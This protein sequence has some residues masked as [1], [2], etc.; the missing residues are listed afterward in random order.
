MPEPSKLF[1]SGGLRTSAA[2]S[3]LV[4]ESGQGARLTTQAGETYFDLTCGY[5]ASNFGQAFPPLVAAAT[6]QLGRLTHVTGEQHVGKIELARALIQ[7]AAAAYQLPEDAFRVQ[8]NVTGARAVETAWKAAVA[9]RPGRI[10]TLSPGFHGRSL[11]TS[12][13]SH[14]AR[15]GP[16]IQPE[17][18]L[19]QASGAYPYC[20]AC[21]LGLRY[22]ECK[23]ACAEPLWQRIASEADSISAVLVEPA[24]GARGYLFPPDEFFQR[25]RQLTQDHGILMIADEVQTGLGR[26]GTWLL[27][28]AQGWCPDL[29]VLGKSLGGGLAPISAVVG[30]AEVLDAIPAGV[31]SET[32]AGSPLACSLART[33]LETLHT[34]DWMSRG[35]EVG[36]SLR[37][38]CRE[39]VAD[40]RFAASFG[41]VISSSSPAVV[42]QVEGRGANC[43]VEF[44]ASSSKQRGSQQICAARVADRMLAAGLLVHLSGPYQTRIVMLPPLTTTD[45]ELSEITLR[46]RTAL[47]NTTLRQTGG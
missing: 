14:T 29:V 22:P 33:V 25:L 15:S 23:L 12:C 24:I 7:M 21:P 18:Y 16:E 20:A 34:G 19:V 39:C 31:E 28:A 2:G 42:C 47:L 3:Q 43:I 6:H 32:F 37:K 35:S 9:F 17:G 11:A 13:I 41:G 30:R 4:F 5:S 8:L 26:C 1:A 38:T 36:E 46:L 27:S 44:A 45:E 40:E 10:L